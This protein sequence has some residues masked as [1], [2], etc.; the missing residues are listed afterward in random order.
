[1]ESHSAEIAGEINNML[2]FRDKLNLPSRV[3]FYLW[4]LSGNRF[5]STF[6][7][8]S[9]M[10]IFLRPMPFSDLATATEV[11]AMQAYEVPGNIKID[12]MRL[13]VDLGANVGYSCIYWLDN[14]PRVRLIAFEP[15]PDHVKQI[16]K[17]IEANSAQEQVTLISKAAGINE[18]RMYL[19][20]NQASSTLAQSFKEGTI[21][22]EVTDWISQ[23]GDQPI[24]LL[25]MD[26]EGSEYTLLSDVRFN[27]LNI[28]ICVVEWHNT[29]KNPNG[30]LWCEKK[31][32]ELGYQF[33]PGKVN[34]SQY[35][36]LWA[37]KS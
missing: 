19:T 11:F 5:E 31:F 3:K 25:K 13:I 8:K 28:K 37:W 1:M 4:R 2:W 35:G 32:A 15:H 20:D 22:V 29:D 27:T 26:I 12:D 14:F 34:D 16:R 30:R 21:A 18:D 23:L 7:L 6:T 36:L 10:H 33:C 24:D 9:G 17:H